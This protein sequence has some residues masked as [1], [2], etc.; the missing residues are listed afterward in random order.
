MA[1][2]KIEVEYSITTS[3]TLTENEKW[4]GTVNL[5]GNVFVPSGK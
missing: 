1:N 3:G 5:T 4:V 2:L